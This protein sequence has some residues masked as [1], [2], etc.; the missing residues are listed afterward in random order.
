MR[1][2]IFFCVAFLALGAMLSDGVLGQCGG[3]GCG[4]QT[5]G[6][7]CGVG[8]SGQSAPFGPGFASRFQ[9]PRLSDGRQQELLAQGFAPNADG[10]FSRRLGA[11]M[12]PVTSLS[13]GGCDVATLRGGSRPPA[14]PG[15]TPAPRADQEPKVSEPKPAPSPSVDMDAIAA[16]IADTL[17]KDERFRGPKGDPGKDGAPGEPGPQGPPG[18]DAD[19]EAIA[20]LVIARLDYDA[21]AARISLP[22]VNAPSEPV[23]Y[24]LV[25]DRGAGYWARL[26]GELATA[27]ENFST[28]ETVEPGTQFSGQ[29]PQLIEYRGRSPRVVAR[30][31]NAVSTALARVSRGDEL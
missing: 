9:P 12:Q 22:P 13:A 31:Q 14:V 8:N 24:V 5:A 1:P 21:I 3:G 4:V 7:G 23:H 19:P 16:K 30:G 18:R 29:M 25:A 15:W 10:S 11:D 17:A 27:R 2:M 6:G 28:I 26:N 20:Q